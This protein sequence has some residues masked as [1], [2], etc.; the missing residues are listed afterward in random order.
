MCQS[1]SKGEKLNRTY[2]FLDR[3]TFM[4][5]HYHPEKGMIEEIRLILGTIKIYYFDKFGCIIKTSLL[6]EAGEYVHIP[7]NMTHTYVVMTDRALTKGFG[8]G[9]RRAVNGL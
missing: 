2:N 3:R 6:K 8:K 7:N 4:R 1:T 5:P 9:R